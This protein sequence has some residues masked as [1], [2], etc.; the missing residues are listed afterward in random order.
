LNDITVGNNGAYSAGADWDP[1]SG[2]GSPDGVA[3]LNKFSTPSTSAPV[4]NF[5]NTLATGTVPFTVNFTDLS[6]GSPLE[7]VWN[8][9]AGNSLVHNTSGNPSYTYSTAGN[10]VASLTVANLNGFSQKTVNITVLNRTQAPVANF[11]AVPVSGRV[12]LTVR[13]TDR[14]TGQ[15]TSWLWNFGNGVTSRVRNPI[16]VYRARGTYTVSLSVTGPGGTVRM[17][18]NNYIVVR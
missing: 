6:T 5:S 7:W 3:L 15:I 16:Y 17:T 18:R 1:C 2:C 11:S 9:G 13:F 4:A 8:F 12:P 10:Y 14:S